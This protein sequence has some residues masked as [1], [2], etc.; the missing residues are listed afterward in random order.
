MGV[1]V[2]FQPREGVGLNEVIAELVRVFGARIIC[3]DW[4]ADHRRS[5]ERTIAS[6]RNGRGL[7]NPQKLL[8]EIDSAAREA[9]LRIVIAVPME[10][11][12]YMIGDIAAS[13][14][15]LTACC[16]LQDSES[17]KAV[18]AF[19]RSLDIVAKVDVR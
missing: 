9:G 10:G 2:H 4:Y 13:R 11:G 16:P 7:S 5:T 19:L 12:G 17:V 6:V 14:L 1:T 3:H 15:V 8:D 18:T